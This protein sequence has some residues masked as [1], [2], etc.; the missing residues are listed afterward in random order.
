VTLPG[1]A[2][3]KCLPLPRSKGGAFPFLLTLGGCPTASA[4]S[5]RDNGVHYKLRKPQESNL[6]IVAL[7]NRNNEAL[8]EAELFDKSLIDV[9]GIYFNY[10]DAGTGEEGCCHTEP[11]TGIGF[12]IGGSQPA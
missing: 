2:G 12:A 3:E 11:V 5:L 4:M 7:S 8:E 6:A 1:F 10:P 9:L